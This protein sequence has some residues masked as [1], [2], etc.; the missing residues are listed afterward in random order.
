MTTAN[1]AD[2]SKGKS[3]TKLP[4]DLSNERLIDFYRQM[5]LIRRFEEKCAEAYAY[6]KIGGF[7]HLYIGEE[8]VAVGAIAALSDKDHLVTHYR[9]HGY[10]LAR[11]CDPGATLAE[12]YG[13]STG[14][15]GGRGGSMHLAD[16]EKRFWGGYAIVAGH[17]PL[18]V[19]IASAIKYR[20]EQEV[21]I[22]FFGDGATNNGYFHE[23]LNIAAV[24][25]LPIIFLVENNNYGMGTAIDTASRVTDIVDKAAGLHIPAEQVDGMDPLPVYEATARLRE[26][27]LKGEGP[28]LLEAKTY[29]L[30]GHSIADAA[31][32]RTKDEVEHYRAGDPIARFGRVLAERGVLAPDEAKKIDHNV[33]A[34]IEAAAKFADESPEPD[35]STLFD[36]IYAQPLG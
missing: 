12:L 2:T 20:R 13:R 21:V 16:V 9:D 5:V 25:D 3:A 24:G 4:V 27:C 33:L 28:F 15:S 6:G 17:I 8:A 18:A 29:R 30:V 1:G 11:G 7:C 35:P 23:A 32:Y 26:R 14:I 19:G 22:C 10:A 31:A 36:Y 34:E